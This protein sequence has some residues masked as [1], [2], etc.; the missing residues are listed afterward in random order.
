M[1]TGNDS[2]RQSIPLYGFILLL[3]T[4]SG[5]FFWQRQLGSSRPEMASQS[6]AAESDEGVPAR[7]WEDPFE[8]TREA[9]G[10]AAGVKQLVCAADQILAVMVPGGNSFEYHEARLRTR[11]AVLSALKAAGRVPEE[12]ERLHYFLR[13]E[14]TLVPFERFLPENGTG[15]VLLLWLDSE[16]YRAKPVQRLHELHGLLTDGNCH[17]QLTVVGPTDSH[18]FG[19][20][21]QDLAEAPD[22][23]WLKVYSPF[24]TADDTA[25]TAGFGLKPEQL[26]RLAGS[27]RDRSGA[28]KVVVRTIATDQEVAGALVDELR[29]RGIQDASKIAV[30]AE[31]DTT[32]GRAFPATLFACLE[33]AGSKACACGIPPVSRPPECTERYSRLI[34]EYRSPS[35][36]SNHRLRHGIYLRGMDGISLSPEK[37]K[38]GSQKADGKTDEGKSR[39]ADSGLERPVG[40]GQLDYLRRLADKLADG[41]EEIA[42][43]GVLGTD[44]YDRL[45]VLQALRPKLPRAIFF[46]VDLDARLL[47]AGERRWARNLLVASS[48]SLDL[49]RDLP[50]ALAESARAQ[51]PFRDNYG[52][53]TYLAVLRAL[54]AAPADVVGKLAAPQVFEI[55]L[56]RTHRLATGGSP[57]EEGPWYR[58]SGAARPL[59]EWAWGALLLALC[60]TMRLAWRGRGDRKLALR[61]PRQLVLVGF[62]ALTGVAGMVVSYLDGPPEPFAWFEGISIW[63]TELLRLVTGFLALCLII[64]AQDRMNAGTQEMNEVLGLPEPA[65]QERPSSFGAYVRL[66]LCLPWGDWSL[67]CAGVQALWRRY[68]R[69]GG[70]RYRWLRV[71]VASAVYLL[72][73]AVVMVLLGPPRAPLRGTASQV[74]DYLALIVSVVPMIVLIWYVFDATLLSYRFIEAVGRSRDELPAGR[75]HQWPS[76]IPGVPRERAAIDF[77]ARHTASVG[78]LILYPFAILALIVL[79]RVG[80]F[81]RWDWPLSLVIILGTNSLL[82]LA[83]AVILRRSA[84]R[85]RAAVLPGL[86]ERHLRS[87]GGDPAAVERITS[88]MD[89]IRNERRGAF[90][91]LSQHPVLG[92]V[93]LPSSS[94]GLASLLE[95]L[96]HG[97][98]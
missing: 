34:A 33:L 87:L 45:L 94:L 35:A 21:V 42:A 14:R 19:R 71:G 51:P 36:G 27:D 7:L 73:A 49:D 93:A 54:D 62:L 25:I 83:C 81:D 70:P 97:F 61:P 48:F 82:A 18:G 89:D 23:R 65:S 30:V 40:R 4:A 9:Q 15:R 8:V 96:A 85:I 64:R 2:V 60:L 31:W 29:A 76:G 90:A 98:W 56:T 69:C 46:T 95:S 24:A 53:A 57:D 1:A 28:G 88:A 75:V 11:Y 20:L 41:P 44:V 43:V 80:Y 50:W 67:E 84:E 5:T 10:G 47:A 26:S 68:R 92:A 16:E 63:P 59:R 13:D 38:E 74:A 17:P 52:T 58:W 55:G 72:G 91:P 3:L 86:R 32:Y 12:Q 78:R 22:Y 6:T 77:L 37:Y 79:A 66:G 39:S